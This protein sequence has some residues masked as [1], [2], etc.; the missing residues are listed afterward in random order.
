M[1]VLY[2][3]NGELKAGTVLERSPASL[4][5]ESPHGRRSKIKAAS[6]LLSFERPAPAELLREAESFSRG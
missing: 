3:E 5:V 4:H 6:V 1:H 2:E